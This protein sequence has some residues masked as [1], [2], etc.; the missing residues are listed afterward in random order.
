MPKPL[1]EIL[2]FFL[3]DCLQGE[4][5]YSTRRMFGGYGVYC[6]WQIFSIYAFDKIYFK[7]GENNLQDYL[8]AGSHIF[9]YQ[10]Q[11]KIATISY[12]ELPEEVLEDK[13]KLLHWI[14]KS[15]AVKKK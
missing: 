13:E 9:S 7:V 14:D 11:G 2:E 5:G 3:S 6:K 15:L 4:F 10:K 12:Y 1:P 8:D